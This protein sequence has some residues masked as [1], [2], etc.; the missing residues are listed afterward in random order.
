V[1]NS[2]DKKMLLLVDDD[3]SIRRELYELFAPHCAEVLEAENG[4]EAYQLIASRQIDVVVCDIQMP[5][6]NGFWLLDQLDLAQIRPANFCYY[7]AISPFAIP[8]SKRNAVDGVFS[9][10]SDFDELCLWL[11]ECLGAS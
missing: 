1:A 9:K 2:A 7:S 8:P 5:M 10:F 11:R 3:S 6:G 4:Q